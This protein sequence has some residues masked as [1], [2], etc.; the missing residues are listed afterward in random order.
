MSEDKVWADMF[1]RMCSLPASALVKVAKDEGVELGYTGGSR[2][3]MARAIVSERMRR[4]QDRERAARKGDAS[5]WNLYT[6][7]F[8]SKDKRFATEA[9]K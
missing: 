1:E 6:N 8:Y 3:S 4:I 5:K 7:A 9:A 2:R